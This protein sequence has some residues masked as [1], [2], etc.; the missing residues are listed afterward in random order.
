MILEHCQGKIKILDPKTDEL[1]SYQQKEHRNVVFNYILQQDKEYV[2]NL[3]WPDMPV[4]REESRQTIKRFLNYDLQ[5]FVCE[6]SDNELRAYNYAKLQL[7]PSDLSDALDKV[8]D[9]LIE[10]GKIQFA[11]EDDVKASI[12]PAPVTEEDFMN[13]PIEDSRH[14]L[15]KVKA[16]IK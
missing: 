10:E 8:L 7:E 13:L 15:N 5:Q 11:T 1:V 3:I 14:P 2:E 12:V 9:S 4:I 16:V 6:I